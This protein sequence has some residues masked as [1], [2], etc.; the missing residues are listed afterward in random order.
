MSGPIKWIVFGENIIFWALGFMLLSSGVYA[1]SER[2]ALHNLTRLTNVALD[3]AFILIVVGLTAVVVGF[4]GCIGALRENTCLLA[5]YALMLGIILFAQLSFGVGAIVFK[6]WLKEQARGQFKLFIT[7]YRDNEDTQDLV[8]WVQSAWLQ[9]CG[10]ESYN[11]WDYNIY[12]N[13]TVDNESAY[14]NPEACG[15]PFSCCLPPSDDAMQNLQ[16]GYDV[17]GTA[18]VEVA[19]HSIVPEQTIF[20]TGCMD[21]AQHWLDKNL[22]P[23]AA[24]S[25]GVAVVQ[26]LGICFAQNLR[27]DIFAQKA[28]WSRRR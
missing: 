20:T 21:K 28:K 19:L 7:S 18:N 26:I 11:D 8:D 25:V 1:W 10:V 6:D 27:T 17:R 9:C 16:C 2:D 24:V 3:P 15:V 5:F 23:V 22:V 12:F 14:K 4:A 13:C